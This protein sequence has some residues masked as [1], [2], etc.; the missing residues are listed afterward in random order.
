MKAHGALVRN[1]RVGIGFAIGFGIE[2]DKGPET[3]E[4]ILKR[5]LH[6]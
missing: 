2:I 3:L 4:R 1:K 5:R 6:H